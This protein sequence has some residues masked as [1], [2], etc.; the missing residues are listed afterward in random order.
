MVCS[1]AECSTCT[2]TMCLIGHDFFRILLAVYYFPVTKH[3]V[4]EEQ[5]SVLL[6]FAI[7]EWRTFNSS[8]PIPKSIID[9][10]GLRQKHHLYK[11]LTALSS[12]SVI[13]TVGY[14]VSA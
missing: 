12:Y 11:L 6:L 10:E 13:C 4:A 14:G 5:M 3:L 8:P 2:S 7:R 9:L 1:L